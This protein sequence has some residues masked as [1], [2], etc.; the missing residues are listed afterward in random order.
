MDGKLCLFVLREEP[1]FKVFYD[2]ILKK[3]S[4]MKRAGVIAERR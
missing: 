1:G 3:I 2:R 4:G